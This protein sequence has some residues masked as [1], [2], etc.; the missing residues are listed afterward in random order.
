MISIVNIMVFIRSI[1]AIETAK[2]FF[3]RI[4]FFTKKRRINGENA[5]DK[6]LGAN[7]RKS[8]SSPLERNRQIIP[9]QA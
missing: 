5:T 1:V 7:F 9:D 8:V 2:I 3:Y 6:C 4:I